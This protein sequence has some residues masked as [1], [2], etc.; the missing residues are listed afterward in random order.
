MWALLDE[1]KEIV[2]RV[3]ASNDPAFGMTGPRL[4]EALGALERA[5]KW[6]LERM[7]AA[8]ND[9][10]AGRPPGDRPPPGRRHLTG[11]R[12]STYSPADSAA[13]ASA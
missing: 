8:P 7:T 5:S 13:V 12:Y 4:R 3:E 6:L 10:L 11:R 1:L 2:G 9:A